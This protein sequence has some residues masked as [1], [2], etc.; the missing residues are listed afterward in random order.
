M[1]TPGDKVVL[2]SSTSSRASLKP[3]AVVLLV[4]FEFK[5]TVK[6]ICGTGAPGGV[7]VPPVQVKV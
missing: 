6:F 7:A 1:G 5:K 4:K 2:G 3:G